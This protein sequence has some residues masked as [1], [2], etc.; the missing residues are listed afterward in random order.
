[1]K[2]SN[3][4]RISIGLC[5]CLVSLGVVAHPKK[6]NENVPKLKIESFDWQG[7]IPSNRLV[8]LK[9]KY[10]SIRSR[11]HS[12]SQ[13]FIHATSQ[14]IGDNPLKPEFVIKQDDNS[15]VIEVVYAEQILDHNNQLRGR[16][17]V[18]IL[19]P[20]DVGIY[21]ESDSGLIKIDKTASHVEAVSQSGDIKLT[22]TGLFSAKTQSGN[23]GLRLRG[24]KQAGHS[25]ASTE[26]GTI[27]AD[28][29]ND[30]DINLTTKTHAD[31]ILNGKK[32]KAEFNLHQGN[33]LTTMTFQSES[34]DI[35]LNVI[36][37][38]SLVS[39]V[40]PANVTSINVD[41][42][43]LPKSKDW[44][45]GDPIIEREDKRN[46]SEENDLNSKKYN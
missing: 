42:R 13:I 9:N 19:M 26:S 23:I 11:N 8:V 24:Q 4:F 40:K 15:L 38:P 22:T 41:L 30:M 21:A 39:S 3:I 5:V 17:D 16:T 7:K 14:L 20:S 29:F 28:I 32:Q 12:D 43:N 2:L 35:K 37:P 44:K 45:P 46:T 31:V 34:G 18:S 36:E 33:N 25:S 10:G 27:N 1:M 6:T